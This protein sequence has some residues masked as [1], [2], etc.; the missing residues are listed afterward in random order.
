MFWLNVNGYI[1]IFIDNKAVSKLRDSRK[2][3]FIKPNRMKVTDDLPTQEE[4]YA[5]K[6]RKR[7]KIFCIPLQPNF[8][9]NS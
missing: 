1:F 9:E 8:T 5:L 7:V 3:P 6:Q 2:G 4:L